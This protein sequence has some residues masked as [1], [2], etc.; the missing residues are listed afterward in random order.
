MVFLR[1]KHVII[2]HAVK[3]MEGRTAY[4]FNTISLKWIHFILDD[5]N[6]FNIIIQGGILYT[7]IR[8][9]L[10]VKQKL[11]PRAVTV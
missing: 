8:N 10:N 9:I 1:D 5:N 2:Q 3:G 7:T 6:M 11:I 4:T